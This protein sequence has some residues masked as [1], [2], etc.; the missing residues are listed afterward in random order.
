MM[1]VAAF[2]P[3]PE[4]T[5]WV[6]YAVNNGSVGSIDCAEIA[7]N[8][9]LLRKLRLWTNH[10]GARHVVIEKIENYGMPVGVDVHETLMFVGR[11]IEVFERI[12][13]KP[14]LVPRRTV[15][16]HLCNSAKAKDS[17]IRQ[18]LI[19]RFGP[20]K[21]RAI[22]GVKCPKCKGKGWAGR[23]HAPCP[24]CHGTKW[25]HPPGPLVNVKEDMWA[26]LAVA[27]TYCETR[28]EA[29]CGT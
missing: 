13:I 3:G 21:D 16:L 6:M 12:G 1:L 15:K 4:K 24:V 18:V 22:G 27:V 11:M 17:N 23:E 25:K 10:H 14:V 7:S 19:D 26:A 5:G 8:D 2:D 20:G 29:A 28:E 9:D